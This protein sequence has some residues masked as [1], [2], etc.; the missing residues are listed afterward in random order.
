MQARDTNVVAEGIGTL[1]KYAASPIHRRMALQNL[2]Q[3]YLH[4]KDFDQA[5]ITAR[6]LVAATNSTFADQMLLLGVLHAAG[7]SEF[8]NQLAT[9]QTNAAT[10]GPEQVQSLVSWL[11]GAG[12]SEAALRWL[13]SLPKEL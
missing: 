13:A 1:Q 9:T 8:Q 12:Q 3:A 2:S 4:I 10:T 7:S 5:V 11:I 6:K